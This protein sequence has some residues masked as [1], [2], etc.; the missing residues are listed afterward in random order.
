MFT[1]PLTKQDDEILKNAEQLAAKH[2]WPGAAGL[3]Q[4][5]VDISPNNSVLLDKLGWYLSRSKRY[6][7]AIKVYVRL[8][9]LEPKLAKWPYMVG[10][11]YYD[12]KKYREAIEW[13]DKALLLFENYLIVLYRKGYAHNQINETDAAKSAFEKC[14]SLWKNLDDEDKEKEKKSYSDA[15]FQLGK[16]F[17]LSGL[18]RKAETLFAEAVRFDSQDAFKFY[19]YG[20]SL[21]KNHKPEE[22]LE[23]LQKA[24]HI[25]PRKDFII[26]CIAQTFIELSRYSEAD[27]ALTRIPEK[28]RKEYIWR[29]LGI[30][31]VAQERIPEAVIAFNKGIQ[32]DPENHNAY[33]QL[34]LAH[35]EGNDHAHAY[36]DFSRAIEIRKNKY[37]LDFPEAKQKLDEINEYAKNM[38][39]DLFSPTADSKIDPM[40]IITKF[41]K[42]KGYGF[43]KMINGQQE[44]FFHISNVANPD[45]LGIGFGV[46]FI[47]E[48]T[49][50]GKR[51][52]DVIVII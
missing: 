43:I 12:Q 4:E 45:M 35:L 29:A 24:D 5:A 32:Q 51:A 13:F 7:E 15:S 19:E 18:S 39:I 46:N 17:L 44:I 20:K 8:S 38:H 28:N 23:Q 2:D 25:E 27:Q 33:Y 31:R 3:C 47:V 10:Y 49:P 14:I 1:P 52:K 37:N 21:L 41:N 50:K 48:E 26:A 34:G 22:A 9:G 11:Q 40:G 16:I 6:I 42:P 30:V 36:K